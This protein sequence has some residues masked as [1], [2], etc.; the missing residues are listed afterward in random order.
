MACPTYI[1]PAGFIGVS[2]IFP[3]RVSEDEVKA[4]TDPNHGGQGEDDPDEDAVVDQG[5][6]GAHCV[7]FVSFHL[8]S[9]IGSCLTN[10]SAAAAAM[11]FPHNQSQ[12]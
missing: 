9:G 3:D 2:G 12:A 5:V 6:G 8:I 10:S 7:T 1:L 11:F 4:G